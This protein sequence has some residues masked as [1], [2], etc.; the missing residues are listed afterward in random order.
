MRIFKLAL[1]LPLVAAPAL[2]QDA[3]DQTAPRQDDT[4][5]EVT[6]LVGSDYVTGDINGQDY[7]TTSVSAGIAARAG[8]FSLSATLPYVI[9]SAPEELIVSHGG[10]FGTPLF[11]QPTT[12]TN[13]VTREGIGDL[14]L[15]AG[16][17]L[18]LGSVNAFVAGN[19]KVPTASR[20]KALG[21]GEVDYGVSG[22]LSRR[23]G[24]AIPFV[25]AGYTFT[26]E[27]EGFDVRNTVS[28]AAGS[29]FV[30]GRASLATL[31]YNY[32]QSASQEV[33]DRQSLGLGLATELASKLQL[34]VNARAGLSEDAPD[35]SLGVSLGLG[36]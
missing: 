16:Y 12:Q 2:A 1:I 27:P 5:T 8:R 34:G 11:S 20:E 31:S 3:A 18:P 23:F 10:L 19:V 15:Q 33:N 6:F 17:Q 26:G 30:L 36:F 24:D 25:T 22:Q 35:A 28:G 29:H 32:E 7:E 13:T 9:T 4:E 14:A 21:T